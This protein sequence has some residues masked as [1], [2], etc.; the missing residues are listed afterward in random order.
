MHHHHDEHDSC[1]RAGDLARRG[2]LKMALVGGAV[3]TV[4]S[5]LPFAPAQ[6]SGTAEALLLSCMDSGWWTTSSATWTGAA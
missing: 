1:C 5:T 2:F 3:A 6:A 4:A